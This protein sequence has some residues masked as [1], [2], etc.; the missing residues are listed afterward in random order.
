MHWNWLMKNYR[1]GLKTVLRWCDG[2]GYYDHILRISPQTVKKN[3]N[4]GCRFV[5]AHPEEG[6][7]GQCSPVSTT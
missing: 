3:K 4:K 2:T 6:V 1:N 5:F 7:L